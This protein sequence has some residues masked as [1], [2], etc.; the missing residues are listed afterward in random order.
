MAAWKPIADFGVDPKTLTDGELE[1]LSRVWADQKSELSDTGSL[2]EFD[3]RLGVSG[4]LR[5][6]LSR[7]STRWIGVLQR[8]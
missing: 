2:E 8:P 7:T 4:R 5:P 6:A 3:K 1:S